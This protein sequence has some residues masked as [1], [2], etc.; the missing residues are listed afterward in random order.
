MKLTMALKSLAGALAFSAIAG[1]ASAATYATF[2]TG[3]ATGGDFKFY[4][5]PLSATLEGNATG[6]LESPHV[7]PTVVRDY[8]FN[9]EFMAQ[10][11]PGPTKSFS[12]SV[13][14][15]STSIVDLFADYGVANPIAD[16]VMTYSN[17]VWNSTPGVSVDYKAVLGFDATTYMVD[18]LGL[19]NQVTTNAEGKYWAKATLTAPV[20]L[21]AAAPLLLA[22]LGGLIAFGRKRRRKAA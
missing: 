4:V 7:D 15:G 9:Y 11:I 6:A 13:H 19:T 1:V 14:I 5:N 22:G 12:G 2:Y 8:T 21:P 17:V 3:G 10:L 20:P 16:L 18:Q